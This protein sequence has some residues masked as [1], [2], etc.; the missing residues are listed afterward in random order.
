MDIFHLPHTRCAESRTNDVRHVYS[1]F[2]D[3][4]NGVSAVRVV[5]YGF[6]RPPRCQAIMALSKKACAVATN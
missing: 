1:L 6:G 2:P 4:S 5:A 3:I